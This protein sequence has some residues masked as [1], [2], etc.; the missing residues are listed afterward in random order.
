MAEEWKKSVSRRQF[1]TLAGGALVASAIL[2]ACADNPT[3]AIRSPSA[4][5]TAAATTGMTTKTVAGITAAGG[6]WLYC[7]IYRFPSPART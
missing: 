7:T 5:T 3:P 1:V 4:S 6:T 2:A